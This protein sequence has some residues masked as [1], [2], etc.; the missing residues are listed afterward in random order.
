[1]GPPWFQ[2]PHSENRLPRTNPDTSNGCQGEDVSFDIS[3]GIQDDNASFNIGNGNPSMGVSLDIGNGNQDD[4]ANINIGNCIQGRDAIFNLRNGILN[5]RDAIN[6]VGAE[7]LE[8]AWVFQ[9]FGTERIFELV[10]IY[11]A[12]YP[13][14]VNCF[15]DIGCIPKYVP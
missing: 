5:G 3:N 1:M 15:L 14:H 11:T 9:S 6:E 4:D 12:L 2:L 7:G 8:L 10:C 13:I